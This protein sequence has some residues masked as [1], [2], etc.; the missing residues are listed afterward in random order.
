MKRKMTP[1]KNGS[2]KSHQSTKAQSLFDPACRHHFL[3]RPGLGEVHTVYTTR[4][5][6]SSS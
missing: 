3:Q 4:K 5:R 6:R 2:G 1:Q